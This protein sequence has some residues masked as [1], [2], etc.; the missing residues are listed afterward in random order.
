M[1]NIQGENHEVI[2]EKASITS[3]KRCTIVIKGHIINLIVRGGKAQANLAFDLLFISLYFYC[4]Y[5]RL[6][7]FFL[8]VASTSS[9]QA[10]SSHRRMKYKPFLGYM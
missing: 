1:C 10:P 9:I 6:F 5:N 8:P 7:P 4:I 2:K 3:P